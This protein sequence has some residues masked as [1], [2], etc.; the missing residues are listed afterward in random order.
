MKFI[1][2]I[3]ATTT[4]TYLILTLILTLVSFI[5]NLVN[6]YIETFWE[7]FHEYWYIIA[8]G[9]LANV[10]WKKPKILPRLPKGDLIGKDIKRYLP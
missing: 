10:V 4:N 3:I 8:L 6:E 9:L 5:G 7:E 2:K 1:L